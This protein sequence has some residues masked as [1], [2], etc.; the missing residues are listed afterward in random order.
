[1]ITVITRK[2]VPTKVITCSNCDSELKYTN[3]DLYEETN[4]SINYDYLSNYYFYCP[5]CGCKQYARW[6]TNTVKEDKV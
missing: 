2:E 1:M 4:R 5:V 6:I 3:S